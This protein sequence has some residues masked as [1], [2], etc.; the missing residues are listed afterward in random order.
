MFTRIE[1][2]NRKEAE[3]LRRGLARPDVRAFVL[4]MGILDTLPS[5]RA[6]ERVLRF[7]ADRQ[8]AFIVELQ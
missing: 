2:K 1:V 4:T 5:D 8:D 6:R 7:I 3:N